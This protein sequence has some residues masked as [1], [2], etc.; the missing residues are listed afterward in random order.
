MISKEQ[1]NELAKTFEILDKEIGCIKATEYKEWCGDDCDTCKFRHP[2]EM[3]DDQAIVL[4]LSQWAIDKQIPAK[5]IWNEKG[6]KE[7][8]SSFC[9]PNCQEGFNG[10]GWLNYCYHCGQALDW[11]SEEK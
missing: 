3:S 8:L 7:F 5:P 9:C 11:Q 6:S 1:I 2:H 4:S 10:K